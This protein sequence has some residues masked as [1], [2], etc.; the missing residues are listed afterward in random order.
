MIKR[1]MKPASD[2]DFWRDC[3]EKTDHGYATLRFAGLFN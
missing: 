1:V 3:K 2:S